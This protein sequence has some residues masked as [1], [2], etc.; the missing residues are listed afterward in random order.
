M[1]KNFSIIIILLILSV[2]A[3]SQNVKYTAKEK[4]EIK[5][6]SDFKDYVLQSI[7]SNYDIN[8][9]I[10]LNY[11]LSHYL[12]I[13]VKND[14]SDT[15]NNLPKEKLGALR[16]TVNSFF[17]FLRQAENKKTSANLEAIPSRLSPDKNIYNRFTTFQKNNT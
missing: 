17:E 11:I 10:H 9:S 7:R 15:M 1:K 8:D 14:S 16:K 12:F 4:T 2:S 5:I 3:F 6:F 13:D